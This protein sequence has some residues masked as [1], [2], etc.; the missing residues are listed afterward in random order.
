VVTDTVAERM[1]P[2]TI[3][4]ISRSSTPTNG[5]YTL[6]VQAASTSG[7]YSNASYGIRL[8]A[9]LAP[10]LAFDSSTATVSGQAAD[11]WQFFRITVPG[12]ALAGN[13]RLTNVTSGTPVFAVCREQ[14]PADLGTHPLSGVWWYP[15]SDTSWPTGYQWAEGY[16]WTGNPTAPLTILSS[17]L[18]A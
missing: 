18:E 5:L 7:V 9:R 16:D 13:L 4:T 14:L 17:A 6:V 1:Q 10:T 11:S 2:I 12:D 3:R 8:H 15:D